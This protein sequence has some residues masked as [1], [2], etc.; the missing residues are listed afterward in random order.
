MRG[1][2]KPTSR[3]FAFFKRFYYTGKLAKQSKANRRD[4]NIE[5]YFQKQSRNLPKQ[6]KQTK[7]SSFFVNFAIHNA[8]PTEGL[9]NVTPH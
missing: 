3:L 9:D 8:S 4:F 1:H 7:M 6:V 5:S 2:F